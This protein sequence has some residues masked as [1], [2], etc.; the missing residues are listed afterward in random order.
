MLFPEE[1]TLAIMKWRLQHMPSTSRW[2]PV[3]QRYVSYLAGRVDGLGGNSGGIE[4]SLNGV[5]PK[6]PSK[7]PEKVYTG[8]I[9][10]VLFDCFGEKLSG[11]IQIGDKKPGLHVGNQHNFYVDFLID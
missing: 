8:K 4:P 10:E 2:Y 6:H 7:R 1:N 5:P 9:S 3:L 11:R